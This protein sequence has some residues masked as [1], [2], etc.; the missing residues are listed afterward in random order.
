M[1][2][3][4]KILGLN[5]FGHNKAIDFINKS[6]I[7]SKTS[8]AYLIIGPENVGK[9]TL[10]VDLASILNARPH[11]DM[12]DNQNIIDISSSKERSRILNG[13]HS[14]IKIIDKEFSHQT[15]KSSSVISIDEIRQIIKDIYLKPFEGEKKIYIINQAQNMTESGYNSMLKILEEP[16]QDAV[17]ILTAPSIKSLPTTIVSRCQLINLNYIQKKDIENFILRNFD[18]DESK[19]EFISR[20]SKGK[21]GFAIN[22]CN[23]QTLI[24][25]YFQTILKFAEILSSSIDKRFNY[26]RDISNLY[27]KNKNQVYKELSMWLDFWRDLLILKNGLNEH[28]VNREWREMILK[29]SNEIEIRKIL[30]VIQ[31]FK[32]STKYLQ[33][34][35]SPQLIIEVLMMKLPFVNKKKISDIKPSI[36]F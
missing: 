24:D 21:I 28:I 8:H 23:D 2:K 10:A 25:D 20:I 29:I 12:F 35:G 19:S 5:T 17:L 33:Q 27:R 13:N 30:D 4:L 11:K 1:N 15:N 34:N 18:I 26:A 31:E 16:P 3:E 6:V 22:A 36:I 7:M 9:K 14:D 32:K